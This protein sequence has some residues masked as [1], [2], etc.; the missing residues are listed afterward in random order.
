MP[1]PASLRA[2][3]AALTTI[4]VA[5]VGYVIVLVGRGR[6]LEDLC[7]SRE[8]AGAWAP[9]EFTVVRGPIADGLIGF[10]CESAAAPQYGFGFTD[11]L[12]LLGTAVVAGV[13][14]VAAVLA[15]RW[16]L[17]GRPVEA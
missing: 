13:V 10:R 4:A 5:A 16:A 8:P 7:L 3:V 14:V 9:P 1:R 2:A 12:P 17:R 6:Y 15:W 11:P